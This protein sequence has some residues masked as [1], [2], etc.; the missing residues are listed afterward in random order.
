MSAPHRLKKVREEFRTKE[1]KKLSGIA[2]AKMLEI[3][4]QYYYDIEKGDRNLSSEIASKLAD[5]FH[6]TT[7]Y[8][9][10][11]ID[12]NIYDWVGHM[13]D[14][15]LKDQIKESSPQYLTGKELDELPIETLAMH[16]LTRNGKPLTEK[17]K[18]K[19]A[20]ILQSAVDL[21]D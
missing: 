6:T 11:K 17:Q 2:V 4:P 10:G 7:D 20:Q 19:F 18:K 16:N 14:D 15:E 3:T 12:I 21:F 13:E 5:I 9:L 8:L 1:G